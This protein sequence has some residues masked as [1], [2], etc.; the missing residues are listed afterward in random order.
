MH[1]P[2]SICVSACHQAFEAREQVLGE[3]LAR[4]TALERRLMEEEQ[5]RRDEDNRKQRCE[6]AALDDISVC[7][8]HVCICVTPHSAQRAASNVLATTKDRASV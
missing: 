5:Q 3:E 7:H 8:G 1:S 4:R 6:S 2:L